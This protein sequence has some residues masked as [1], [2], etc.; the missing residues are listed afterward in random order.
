LLPGSGL[1]EN[2][3]LYYKAS[4]EIVER[5]QAEHEIKR[6][7]E[8]LE[9]RVKERTSELEAA[10]KELHIEVAERKQVE[11]ALKDS[12]RRLADIIDFLPDATFV[13]NREGNVIAWNKAI[14]ALT[15]VKSEEILGLGNY[16]Y[17]LPFHGERRAILIDLVLKADPGRE[18]LRK[19]PEA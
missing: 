13:V 19:Y 14:E 9:K 16:E 15:G 11:Y 10:N 7:N 5:K 2:A 18:E 3:Q 6:L 4:Q 8:E 12:E 1:N 17:S